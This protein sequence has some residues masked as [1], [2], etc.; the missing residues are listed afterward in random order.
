[1]PESLFAL[2]AWG[3]QR[4]KPGAGAG[5]GGESFLFLSLSSSSSV[6]LPWL[7]LSLLWVNSGLFQLAGTQGTSNAEVTSRPN[8]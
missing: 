8:L 5:Q 7:L 2:L 1:M 4:D 6:L 3:M